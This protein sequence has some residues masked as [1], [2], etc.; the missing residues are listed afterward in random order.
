ML[1]TM[2]EKPALLNIGDFVGFVDPIIS[3]PMPKVWYALRLH[4]NYDVKAERKLLEHGIS[5]YVPKEK[6]LIKT[7]WG[8]KRLREIPIFSGVL[9]VPD[10]D[11]DL[12]LLKRIASGIGGFVKGRDSEALEIS[13]T[14]MDAIRRFEAKL[15]G[16][17]GDRKFKVDQKVR[18]VGGQFD[19]WEGKVQRLD[20]HYRL[21]VLLN[22]MQGEV[23][24]ELGE[25]Q[26]EAV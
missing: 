5:A 23:P 26:V 7:V 15:Q 1:M 8:R 14:W 17:S 24:V 6:K 11:A 9:F 3:A 10:F 4:P 25:D 21:R 2:T 20:S 19:M 12:A 13:L 16:L 22:I 18:I